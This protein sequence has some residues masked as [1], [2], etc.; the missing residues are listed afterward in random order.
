[1]PTQDD[2]DPFTV[3]CH[4]GFDD[5]GFWLIDVRISWRDGMPRQG[6]RLLGEGRIAMLTAIHREAQHGRSLGAMKV[7]VHMEGHSKLLG[8]TAE[9][10]GE[11]DLERI[12][13]DPEPES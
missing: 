2:R 8:K 1:M 3:T 9:V 6:S 11:G 4:A 10:F 5:S 12:L 13:P 7:R